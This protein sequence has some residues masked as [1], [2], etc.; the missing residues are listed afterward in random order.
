MDYDRFTDDPKL[1]AVIAVAVCFLVILVF[2]VV[3]A[4]CCQE[5][6][7]SLRR[8]GG[9]APCTKCQLIDMGEAA[10]YTGYCPD[11]GDVPPSL[12]R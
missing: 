11:C 1:R 5:R 9:R 3:I 2:G 12:R 10:C 4:C 7:Q 6:I 8:G